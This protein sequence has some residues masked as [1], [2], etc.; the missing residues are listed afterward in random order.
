MIIQMIPQVRDYEKIWYEVEE[1]K[2]AITINDV[3]DTFDFNGMPD[4]EL[5]IWDPVN[6]G[7]LVDTTLE[8]V[9]IVSAKKVGGV[10]TVEIICSISHGES[11]ERLL[12]PEPLTVEEF[13]ELMDELVERKEHEKHYVDGVWVGPGSPYEDLFKNPQEDNEEVIE[14]KNEEFDIEEVDF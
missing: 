14:Y 13:N 7:Y 6:G 12:F 3:T 1:D 2:I 5:Q 9:P 8:E 10:L 4:G 11:D